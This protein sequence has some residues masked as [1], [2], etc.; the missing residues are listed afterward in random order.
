MRSI[1]VWLGAHRSLMRAAWIG[2]LLVLAACN[3]DGGG[4]GG[5]GGVPGY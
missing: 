4:G 1:E 3:N 2:L 5:G